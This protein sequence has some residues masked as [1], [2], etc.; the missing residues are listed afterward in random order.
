MLSTDISNPHP[1]P[2]SV[3]QL[4]SGLDI[5]LWWLCTLCVCGGLA[6]ICHVTFRITVL[7]VTPKEYLIR[8]DGNHVHRPSAHLSLSL[9]AWEQ[10][11]L[12]P[13]RPRCVCAH[14]LMAVCRMCVG[15]DEKLIGLWFVCMQRFGHGWIKI[16]VHKSINESCCLPRFYVG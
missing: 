9:S 7:W 15:L 11:Y 2:M 1:I 3:I 4:M 12:R 5:T 8:R 10:I 16:Y 13:A 14:S 6:G